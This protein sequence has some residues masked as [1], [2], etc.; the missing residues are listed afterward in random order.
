MVS[1][2]RVL[3]GHFTHCYNKVLMFPVH[4]AEG[5]LLHKYITLHE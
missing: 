1:K 3:T 2:N 4:L 5:I